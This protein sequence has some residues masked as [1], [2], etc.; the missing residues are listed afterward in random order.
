MA[1]V[2]ATESVG[3]ALGV[4]VG[5]T[6]TGCELEPS[7]PPQLTAKVDRAIAIAREPPERIDNFGKFSPI[8]I[9]AWLF[10]PFDGH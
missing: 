5:V 7:L 9:N 8:P 1:F 2:A 10:K 6:V 3:V 4:G